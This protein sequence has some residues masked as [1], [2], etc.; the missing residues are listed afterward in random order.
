[1]ELSICRGSHR[2]IATVFDRDRKDRVMKIS[3]IAAFGLLLLATFVVQPGQSFAQPVQNTRPGPAARPPAAAP[4]APAAPSPAVPASAAVRDGQI[5][6]D[7]IASCGKVEGV[8]NE[9]CVI[10]Q[11]RVNSQS[12]RVM[13][14]IVGYIGPNKEPFIV[15]E[16]PLGVH[17]PA[18]AA[19]RVDE[20]P[21][22]PMTYDACLPEGCRANM[23]LDQNVIQ[24]LRTGQLI[25]V[26]FLAS[27]N[28]ETVVL[29]VSLK[30]FARGFAALRP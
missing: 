4:P 19:F 3:S 9:R 30:G 13:R 28:S 18:G 11:T 14:A 17:L 1:M 15:F 23:F 26:G 27:A 25:R 5:F 22:L 29:D 10:A 20:G 7:W 6:D 24:A 8:Q 2:R 16:L 12:Q 21:Q